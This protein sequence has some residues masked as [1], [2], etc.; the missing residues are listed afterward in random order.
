MATDVIK[1][2]ILR[3]GV[4]SGLSRWL[5]NAIACTL[6]R[7]RRREFWNGHTEKKTRRREGGNV[8][9]EVK[10]GVMQ[11]Q[12]WSHQK[13]EEARN[14]FSLKPPEESGFAD[15]LISDFQLPQLCVR[16][17]ISVLSPPVY[18][19]LFTTTTGLNTQSHN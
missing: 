7:E 12:A 13:P 14:R 15:T 16:E 5:L 17:Y 19:N 2:S 6:I 9:T 10:I 3:G 18:E 11:S 4:H 8:T 1:F